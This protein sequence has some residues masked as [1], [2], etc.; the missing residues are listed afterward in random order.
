VSLKPNGNT[1]I[2]NAGEINN[3]AIVMVPIGVPKWDAP[4]IQAVDKHGE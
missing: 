3:P 2:N 1:K 4:S